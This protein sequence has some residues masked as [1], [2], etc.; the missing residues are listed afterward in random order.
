MLRIKRALYWRLTP[1]LGGTCCCSHPCKASSLMGSSWR[2]RLHSLRAGTLSHHG[3]WLLRA[4]VKAQACRH[5]HVYPGIYAIV[6][7]CTRLRGLTS[8]IMP[9]QFIQ[10]VVVAEPAL[11]QEASEEPIP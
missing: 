9:S 7:M 11:S 1:A 4:A 3:D 2:S 5:A 10:A 8:M 6:S